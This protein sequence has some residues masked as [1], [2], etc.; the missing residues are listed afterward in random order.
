MTQQMRAVML[1]VCALTIQ[2]CVGGVLFGPPVIDTV[3][4]TPDPATANDTL[5]CEYDGFAG[6]ADLSDVNYMDLVTI[7]Q[8]EMDIPADEADQLTAQAKAFVNAIRSGTKPVVTAE[9]GYAAVDA[10]ERI[11]S[12]IQSHA[13]DGLGASPF[14]E[15]A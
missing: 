11:V 2:G 9:Q 12:A 6:G 13:W 5:T 8:L 1:T 14:E 7:D 3:R 10:A 15:N 4:I